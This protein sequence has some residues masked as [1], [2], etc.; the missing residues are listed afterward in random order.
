MRC[1]RSLA[2]GVL[3]GLIRAHQS[4]T[5]LP[6]VL[7]V[8]LEASEKVPTTHERQIYLGDFPRHWEV[9]PG[10]QKCASMHFPPLLIT[11]YHF[12]HF[13]SDRSVS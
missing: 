3:P 8:R 11:F 1:Y 10:F 13:E 9:V 7:G 2:R 4:H 6:N 12:R 5:H